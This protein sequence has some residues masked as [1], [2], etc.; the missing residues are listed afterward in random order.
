MPR[1]FYL[2]FILHNLGR[3][4]LWTGLTVAGIVVA[5]LA[6]AFLRTVVDTW[7]A[8]AETTS[9][10]RLITRN[11]VSLTFPLPISYLGRIRRTSGVEI[12]SYANWFAS[13][14]L[15]EKNFFPQFAVDAR[16]YLTLYP[17]FMSAAA[18]QAVRIP[19]VVGLR[20]MG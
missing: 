6:F 8:E 7:Y 12:V 9:A 3:R 15:N 4:P 10:K 19:I 20:G 18:P 5:V 1:V 16:D 14:Y 17:E 11:A 13:V 2:R